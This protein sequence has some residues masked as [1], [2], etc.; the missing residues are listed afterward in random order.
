MF[1]QD[2]HLHWLPITVG[3]LD[4]ALQ[5]PTL[6]KSLARSDQNAH[7]TLAVVPG[8]LWVYALK[9]TNQAQVKWSPLPGCN[10]T[11]QAGVWVRPEFKSRPTGHA[12]ASDCNGRTP[13]TRFRQRSR[14]G[15]RLELRRFPLQRIASGMEQFFGDFRLVEQENAAQ[16][17]AQG[18]RRFRRNRPSNRTAV[19][20]QISSDRLNAKF[21]ASR[22]DVHG[23]RS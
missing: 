13:I 3:A 11:T 10:P 15:D 8:A 1:T 5:R 20:V 12:L 23:F 19:R 17:T 6:T 14:I 18:K 7:R 22:F 4:R 16:D 2:Q 21:R 9:A